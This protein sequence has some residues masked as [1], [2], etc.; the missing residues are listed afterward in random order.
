M[1]MY[2]M[3]VLLTAIVSLICLWHLGSEIR[4]DR[5]WWKILLLGLGTILFALPFLIVLFMV[6]VYSL[7][8]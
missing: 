6:H 4:G 1:F 3:F 2:G 5:C 8:R 7:G